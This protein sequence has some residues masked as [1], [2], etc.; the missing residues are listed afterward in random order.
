MSRAT[1]I[2]PVL[3]IENSR[4]SVDVRG[5][6]AAGPA[7]FELVL[8]PVGVASNVDGDGVVEHRVEDGGC[9]DAELLLIPSAGRFGPAIQKMAVGIHPSVVP[10]LNEAANSACGVTR[11]DR[12]PDYLVVL[13]GLNG[14]ANSA[15]GVT[16]MAKGHGSRRL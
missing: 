4:P 15:C 10:R 11:D 2:G 8:E 6:F 5:L 1:Q 14:A 12:R 13:R 9:D 16:R 7:G 3:A